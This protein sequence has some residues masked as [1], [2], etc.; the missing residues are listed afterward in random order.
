MKMKVASGRM[1]KRWAITLPLQIMSLDRTDQ[2]ET[3]VMQNVS[4]FGARIV[5]ANS[6]ETCER[7]VI[8]SPEGADQCLAR[9]IYRQELRDGGIAIGVQL[10]KARPPWMGG[11]GRGG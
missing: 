6:W 7:I 2:T 4:L 3:A 10:E 11:D 5:V 8:R 9:V 1:E